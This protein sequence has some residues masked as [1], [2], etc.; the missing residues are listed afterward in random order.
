MTETELS[1]FFSRDDGKELDLSRVPQ[2]LGKRLFV[3]PMSVPS[4][5]AGGIIL[6]DIS[7]E[8]EAF[9]R[10][11][12]LVVAMGPDIGRPT[13]SDEINHGAPFE[14]GDVVLYSKYQ[15]N[16]VQVD[17]IELIALMDED[18]IAVVPAPDAIVK[19]K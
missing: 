5:T 1:K 19:V 18:V 16:K 10:S 15:S 6:A 11:I 3:R 2:P 8:A 4:K 13:Y 14:L 12:G 9:V 17:G 7:K